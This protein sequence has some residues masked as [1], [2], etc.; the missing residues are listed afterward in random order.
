MGLVLTTKGSNSN[1]TEPNNG[2]TTT[3]VIV[4]SRAVCVEQQRFRPFAQWKITGELRDH[5][6]RPAAVWLLYPGPERGVQA[7]VCG[8]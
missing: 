5:F 7:V 1:E 6:G 4:L 3:V 8:I 2:L